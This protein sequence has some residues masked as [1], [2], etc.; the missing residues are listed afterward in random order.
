MSLEDGLR[1][2]VEWSAEQEAVDQVEQAHNEL[3][4]RGLIR[5]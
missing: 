1:N 5:G 3:V 2:L 4:S